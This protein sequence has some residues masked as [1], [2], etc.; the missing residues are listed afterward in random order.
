MLI[1]FT[2]KFSP[3]VVMFGN[4]ASVL[5]NAMG[6]NETPPGILRGDSIKAAADKLRQYLQRIP[7]PD[8]EVVVDENE[9]EEEAPDEEEEQRVS[10]SLRAQ[11]LLDM[12]DT[13]YKEKADVIWR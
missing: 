9:D 7:D 4:I 12:L 5:L 8:E 2:S 10:L 1:T 3:D 11:P 6:Q 13:A